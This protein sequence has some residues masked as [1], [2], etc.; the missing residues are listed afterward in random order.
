MMGWG[1]GGGGGAGGGGGWLQGLAQRLAAMRGGGGQGGGRPGM[2]FGGMGQGFPGMGMGGMGQRQMPGGQPGGTPPI[3]NQ[4]RSMSFGNWGAAQ[5]GNANQ[6]AANQSNFGASQN[7]WGPNGFSQGQQQNAAGQ[8]NQGNFAA[9]QNNQGFA[10]A[11]KR[12]QSEAPD[13]EDDA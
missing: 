13:E 8:Q 2:G 6:A 12:R 11:N 10:D 3:F 4:P 5:G 1:M 7:M 9:A